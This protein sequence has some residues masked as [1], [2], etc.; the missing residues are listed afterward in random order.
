MDN[1]DQL[2]SLLGSLM[3][4]PETLAN[5]RSTAESYGLGELLNGAL[6]SASESTQKPSSE[7]AQKPSSENA[8]EQP[9]GTQPPK[10]QSA[11]GGG[12]GMAAELL[13]TLAKLT[14]AI[15]ALGGDDETTRL[16]NALRPFVSEEKGH[17]IDEAKKLLSLL[18][19]IKLLGKDGNGIL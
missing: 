4:D 15:S 14:P 6:D 13:P 10:P 2:S 3:S 17:K 18:R 7:S 8:H 5:L 19:V 12:L 9:V 11:D 1:K 16:L